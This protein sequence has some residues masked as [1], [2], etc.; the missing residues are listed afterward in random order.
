MNQ[1]KEIHLESDL[2]KCDPTQSLSELITTLD[3]D[4]SVISIANALA[5]AIL[6]SQKIEFCSDLKDLSSFTKV[7]V[8][9]ILNG[10]KQ[11]AKLVVLLI[12]L[13]QSDKHYIHLL[14]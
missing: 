13:H 4:P 1:N 5:E 8:K 10:N 14:P 11:A 7:Y 12:K 6:D 9:E 2:N 3:S